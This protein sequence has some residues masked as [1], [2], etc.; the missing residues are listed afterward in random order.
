MSATTTLAPSATKRR[1]VAAP[2]PDAAPVTIATLPSSRPMAAF[3][4]RV[5]RPCKQTFVWDGR[6]DDPAG[7]RLVLRDPGRCPV[8][9]TQRARRVSP[10]RRPGRARRAGRLL[11]LLDGRASL[12]ERVLAL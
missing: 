3:W 10:G 11:A 6:H 7:V 8:A 2:I 5:D 4:P 1:A 12:P 9:R